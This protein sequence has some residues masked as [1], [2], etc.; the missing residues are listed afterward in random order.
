MKELILL[1][2]GTIALLHLSQI[3]Y[4][5]DTRPASWRTTVPHFLG[6]K[7][8][9]FIGIA[10]AWLTC[11]S[12][13]RTSYN[14]T[15]TYIKTFNEAVSLADGFRHG[16]FLSWFDD[17]WSML[18]RSVVRSITENYH[19]YFFFPA[20]LNTLAIV[21][22]FKYHSPSP[23]LSLLIFLSLGTY[24]MY[25]TALKQCIA[26]FFL[27]TAIPYAINKKYLKFFLT[28][29]VAGMFHTYALVFAIIPLLFEKPWGKVTWILLGLML[30]SMATYDDTLGAFI[31]Y[32]ESMGAYISE[33]EVF[34][35]SQ[36]NVLRVM[37]YWVPAVFALVFRRRLFHDATRSEILFA[38][39]S[40]VSAV[41]LTLGLVKG[42]NLMGRMAGYF[43][44]ASCLALPWMIHKVFTRES[45]KLVTAFAGGLFFVY[46][47]YE[48]A[49]NKNFGSNYSAITLW[50]FI[51]ELI[52]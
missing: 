14:D 31:E 37:V 7:T 30:F 29:F 46:F 51:C 26:I 25:M 8:D 41:F 11:F 4:A 52:S 27:I 16:V 13:L 3:Y 28:V 38:N 45:A 39:I 1:Y 32:T 33:N 24:I 22:L 2:F 17:P 40:I 10:I 43:E 50:Q 5:P 44:F 18:Y 19:I 36:L 42:A 35:D 47:I 12:F 23:A 6:R 48:F 20:F 49:I 21:K 15:E 9:L 34:H